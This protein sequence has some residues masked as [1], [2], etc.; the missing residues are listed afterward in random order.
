[1]SKAIETVS[2]HPTEKLLLTA[3][4]DGSARVW[5]WPQVGNAG[6]IM[7]HPRDVTSAEFSPDGNLVLTACK[8]GA[9]RIWDWR[10]VPA[11]ETA[12]LKI[13]DEMLKSARF[14]S[15]G[16]L[17]VTAGLGGT[18]R[19]WN[20]Q[21]RSVLDTYPHGESAKSAVFHPN[22]PL[23]LSVGRADENSD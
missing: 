14:N 18:I 10:A 3:S 21:K 1:H 17:I 9:A 20:W 16:T 8:D 4:Q 12:L 6:V 23:T 11:R 19:I 22:S 7:P 5:N 2:F 15:N 13:S